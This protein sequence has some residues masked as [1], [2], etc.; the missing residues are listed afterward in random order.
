MAKKSKAKKKPRF[1]FVS[2]HEFKV[3]VKGVIKL[4][5]T[6]RLTDL[7][8]REGMVSAEAEV[9]EALS[10]FKSQIDG[11]HEIRSATTKIHN[12][13]SWEDGCDNGDDC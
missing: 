6:H 3:T 2:E 11:K 4:R 10:A 7:E 13:G 8:I 1:I 12:V 5:S 9:S